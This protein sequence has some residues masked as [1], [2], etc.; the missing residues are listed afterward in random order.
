MK[1]THST[2]GMSVFAAV[3]SSLCCITPVLAFLA[4]TSGLAS[5]FSWIEPARPWLLGVTATMLGFAW[6]QKLKPVA[7]TDQC[8]C[9]VKTRTPFL[10]SKTFLALVTVFAV[11]VAAFPTY[12]HVFYPKSVAQPILAVEKTDVQKVEFTVRGMT[13]TGCEHHVKSEVEKLPGILEAIV[14]YEKGV[15]IVKFD[16]TKTSIEVIKKA[17]NST[18]YEV[19][20]HK[21]I[22]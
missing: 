18:G 5:S 14:S 16:S 2:L 4:G 22:S 15:A 7:A 6:Y 8:G 12:A 20:A 1:S 17:I 10:Q 3:A 21:I 11:I 13:C 19:T 9:E